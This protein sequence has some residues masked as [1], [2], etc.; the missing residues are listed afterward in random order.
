MTE[1]ELSNVDVVLYA[2][3]KL[4]G[5]ERKIHTEEIAYEAHSLAK[6]RFTWRLS[7]FRDMGFPDKE[8]VRRALMDAAKEKY[9][10]LAEGRAGV[11]AKGKET[12]GWALTPEGVTWIRE[13][14]KRITST[15]GTTRAGMPFVDALRF[16]VR[17][18]EQRLFRRFLE[19]GKL[20]GQNLYN[21]TDMLNTSPGAPKEEIALKFRKLHSTAEL[22]ADQQIISFLDACAQAFSTVLT[23]PATKGQR[24]ESNSTD[25]L[26]L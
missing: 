22:V 24:P 21:F 8:P 4:G 2:L 12:D 16:K 1:P 10:H 5:D 15:L 9:G 6:E 3:F 11:H 18:H 20:E 19:K 7:R 14:E 23:S 17:M 13:N 26:L 25:D